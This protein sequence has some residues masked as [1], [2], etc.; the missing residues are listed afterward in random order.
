MIEHE[1]RE[2]VAQVGC[3]PERVDRLGRA[4]LPFPQPGRIQMRITDQ[5]NGFNG[6]PLFKSREDQGQTK[7]LSIFSFFPGK[8][9]FRITC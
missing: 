2:F 5:M 6:A 4:F 3:G 9:E 8:D 7:Y 1:V